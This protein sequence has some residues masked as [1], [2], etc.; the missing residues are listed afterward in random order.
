MFNRS[1]CAS[2]LSL[3]Y[4]EYDSGCVGVMLNN[5]SGQFPTV[6]MVRVDVLGTGP[7]PCFVR[8]ADMN[9]DCRRDLIVS[10]TDSQR[11]SV[12]LNKLPRPAECAGNGGG[13]DSLQFGEGD[14]SDECELEGCEWGEDDPVGWDD[15]Q[16]VE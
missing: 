3:G 14:K 5:G 9:N 1:A 12:V 2:C 10:N 13:G 4:P 16:E 11:F 15:S 6:K 7:K 8:I